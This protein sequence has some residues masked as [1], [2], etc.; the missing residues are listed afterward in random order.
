M[1]I[2]KQ[3]IGQFWSL[4]DVFIGYSGQP[5]YVNEPTA[6]QLVGRG[7]LPR[8]F[9]TIGE[10]FTHPDLGPMAMRL[11]PDPCNRMYGRSDFLIHGD[12]PRHVGFSSNGCIVMPREAREAVNAST[13]KEL[14]VT[15]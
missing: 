7:P 8:G 2:Y 10:A 1:W 5:P 6:Q 13:D 4:P 15:W 11:T 14:E 12:N 3:I 9:Y